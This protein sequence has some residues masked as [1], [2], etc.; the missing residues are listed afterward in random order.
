MRDEL[1]PVLDRVVDG[2]ALFLGTP[3][4]LHNITG[5]MQSFLERFIF[6]NLSYDDPE[7]SYFDGR[8]NIGFFFAMGMP[9]EMMDSFNYGALIEN[10]MSWKDLFRGECAYMT[11]NDTYQFDDYSRYAAKLFDEKHKAEVRNEQFPK[12][13]QSAY[14]LG[15]RLTE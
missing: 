10:L 14:D 9:A 15:K 13:C 6:M 11:S 4:Y 12:D 8:M 2:D 5:A 3:I 7:E 1:S